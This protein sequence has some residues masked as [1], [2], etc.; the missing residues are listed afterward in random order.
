MTVYLLPPHVPCVC[1]CTHRKK[2]DRQTGRQ[3]DTHT[4][5]IETNSGSWSMSDVLC[6]ETCLEEVTCQENIFLELGFGVMM[7]PHS[8]YLVL[9]GSWRGVFPAR[10]YFSRV[11]R[12]DVRCCCS[13]LL[14]AS[15]WHLYRGC[16][17]NF[18][19]RYHFVLRR[20]ASESLKCHSTVSVLSL[21]FRYLLKS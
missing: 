20:W 2:T 15:F 3:T 8:L 19:V 9:L 10:R 1:L 21:P 7:M 13:K 16:K 18:K 5:G 4:I 6:V 14:P 11:G 17:L 12:E